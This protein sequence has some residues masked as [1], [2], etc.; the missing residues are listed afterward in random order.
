MKYNIFLVDVDDTILDFHTSAINAIRAAFLTYGVEWKEDYE[1]E[2]VKF[3]TSLW[4]QLE[5]KEITREYLHETRFPR[6]LKILRLLSLS[7]A[8]LKRVDICPVWIFTWR[9]IWQPQAGGTAEVL[10]LCRK[11]RENIP[12][13]SLHSIIFHLFANTL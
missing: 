2:F 11:A 3:N 8:Q 10:T 1:R 6:Y 7:Y 5:R 9:L 4:A 13:T 12:P